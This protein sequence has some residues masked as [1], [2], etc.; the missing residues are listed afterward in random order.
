MP[1]GFCLQWWWTV[2]VAQALVVYKQEGKV[3]DVGADANHTEVVEHIKKD[4]GQVERSSD[5]DE[6][7]AH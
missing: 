6:R 3:E 4:I 7:R 5:G 1:F 2:E